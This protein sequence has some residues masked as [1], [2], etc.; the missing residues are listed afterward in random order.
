MIFHFWYHFWDKKK[1]LFS[2]VKL[3]CPKTLNFDPN[4]PVTNFTTLN[5]R[6]LKPAKYKVLGIGFLKYHVSRSLSSKWTCFK[7]TII[8][9]DVINY[10]TRGKKSRLNLMSS[11]PPLY[12]VCTRV[13]VCVGLFNPCGRT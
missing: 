7:V 3:T 1:S 8:Q 9:V 2:G 12:I 4:R 13:A 10:Q 6:V 5:R 11:L